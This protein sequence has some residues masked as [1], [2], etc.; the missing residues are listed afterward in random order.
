EKA[1]DALLDVVTSE[2][3]FLA[4]REHQAPRTALVEVERVDSQM[5]IDQPLAQVEIEA[6]D[7]AL[8][9]GGAG[10]P[11][12]LRDA[13]LG[14]RGEELSARIQEA[15][16]APARGGAMLGDAHDQRVGPP[17]AQLG[18]VDPGEGLETRSQLVEIERPET[19]LERRGDRRFDLDRRHALERA[20]DHD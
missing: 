20:L 6:R 5:R 3:H 13:A 9:A 16:V 8:A 12:Q 15:L 2:A 19:L 7:L 4:A 18:R 10:E 11:R 1:I 17:P 14:A